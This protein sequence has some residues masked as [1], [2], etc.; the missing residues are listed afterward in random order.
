MFGESST[1]RRMR[2]FSSGREAKEFLISRILAEAEQENVILSEV[3]RKM[4]YFSETAWTLPDIMTVNEDF[5]RLYDQSEYEKKIAGIIRQAYK[6]A[7]KH[8]PEEYESWRAAI[9]RLEKEDHYLSV[10][11]TLAGLRPRGDQLKLFFAGMGVASCLLLASF[12]AARYNIKWPS[13]EY[14][15]A[16]ALCAV[17]DYPCV[18]DFLDRKRG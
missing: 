18:K 9:R 5:D 13:R 12:L 7:C 8:S 10:M 15:W 3:E 4:L 11:V 1:I 14:L 16:I 2:A 6:R 17:I